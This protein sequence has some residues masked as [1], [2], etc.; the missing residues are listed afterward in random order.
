V[1]S[2]LVWFSESSPEVNR[3]LGIRGFWMPAFMQF[4]T[5]IYLLTGLTWFN[6]FGKAARLNRSLQPSL[7]MSRWRYCGIMF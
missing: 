1:H 2:G 3:T 4:L 6:V 5:G 7:K